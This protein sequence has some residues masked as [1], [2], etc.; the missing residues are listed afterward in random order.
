MSLVRLTRLS[1][2]LSV[3]S[4]AA[5]SDATVDRLDSP[6]LPNDASTAELDVS[7]RRDDLRT[8]NAD[9]GAPSA[10][11]ESIVP[12]EPIA[13]TDANSDAFAG[14]SLRMARNMAA[15]I[16]V[17]AKPSLNS[18]LEVSQPPSDGIATVDSRTRISYRA[19][20]N[21]TG[22]IAFAWRSVGDIDVIASGS[23][24]VEILDET[25]IKVG[26]VF[27]RF[28]RVPV[29]ESIPDGFLPASPDLPAIALHMALSTTTLAIGPNGALFGSFQDPS[30]DNFGFRTSPID[31]SSFTG[32]EFSL[33]KEPVNRDVDHACSHTEGG[34][35]AF[36]TAASTPKEAPSFSGSH[37]S[38]TVT[39]P[40]SGVGFIRYRASQ[41]G[42]VT[43]FLYPDGPM[44]LRRED[45][46]TLAPALAVRSSTCKLIRWVYQFN[47]PEAGDYKFEVGPSAVAK[48]SFIY[49]HG[50]P[51]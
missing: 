36:L 33:A 47:I 28:I 24:N 39:M 15:T 31:L 35:F 30:G 41:S 32:I 29:G 44:R 45:G 19:P 43:F 27:H 2:V 34:P 10:D 6:S 20:W 5:C 8:A 37:T 25:W 40:L 3:I 51:Y 17:D 42:L 23:V 38:Y 50:W 22:K 13:P 48:V 18:V 46:S 4:A 7:P 21:R 11:A 12:D 16:L 14:I 1:L 49:E 26:D 9:A